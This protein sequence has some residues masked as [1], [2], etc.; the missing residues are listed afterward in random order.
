[1]TSCFVFR[2]LMMFSMSY[3]LICGLALSMMTRRS[4]PGGG[5]SL[6]VSGTSAAFDLNNL[7]KLGSRLLDLRQTLTRYDNEGHEHG[8]T[9]ECGPALGL[10][11]FVGT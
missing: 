1:M 3:M 7:L 2:D 11:R 10:A 4:S 5:G 8:R 6:K 9:G